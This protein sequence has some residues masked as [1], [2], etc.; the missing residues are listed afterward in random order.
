MYYEMVHLLRLAV[1]RRASD[2]TIAPGAPPY[3]TVNGSLDFLG[4]AAIHADEAWRMLDSVTSQADQR[5][6]RETGKAD[7]SFW[8]ENIARFRVSAAVQEGFSGPV[9]RLFV[10]DL[11]IG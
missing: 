4:A 9:M 8:F 10:T 6:L 5:Y 1:D 11:N 7:Y 2:L 3:A